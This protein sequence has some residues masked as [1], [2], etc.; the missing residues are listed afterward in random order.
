MDIYL[1]ISKYIFLS[2]NIYL[3][4]LSFIKNFQL[5]SISGSKQRSINGGAELLFDLV[6]F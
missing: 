6:I 4:I 1:Y 5:K 3:E 2:L